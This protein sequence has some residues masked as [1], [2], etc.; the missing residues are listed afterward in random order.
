MTTEQII[1]FGIIICAM[2]MFR[3]TM[4]PGFR[5]PA[6]LLGIGLLLLFRAAAIGHSATVVGYAAAVVAAG[7][8]ILRWWRIRSPTH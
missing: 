7:L 8:F 1:V 5:L 4:P 2:V 3:L 6:T